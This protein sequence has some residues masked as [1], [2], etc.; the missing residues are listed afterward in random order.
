VIAGDPI[1]LVLDLARALLARYLANQAERRPSG[2]S[3]FAVSPTEVAATLAGEGFPAPRRSPPHDARVD[4]A[5]AALVAH[6][7]GDRGGLGPLGLLVRRLDLDELDLVILATLVAVDLDPELERA[8]SFALDDFTRKRPD[9]GFVVRL[10]GA[11]DR[12]AEA[13]VLA[14]LVDGAALRRRQ[15]V[16]AAGEGPVALRV[17]RAADRVAML[18]RGLDVIDEALHGAAWLAPPIGRDAVVIDDAVYAGIARALERPTAR[19]LLAGRPGTGRGLAVAAVAA[20]RGDPVLR[21]DL[22]R[23]ADPRDARSAERIA[24]AVREAAL[25]G[26]IALFDGPAE[27]DGGE[28]M[29]AALRALAAAAA[30]VATPLALTL[31]S[32]PAWLAAAFPDLVEID[33]P[34]PGLA[35][36]IDLWRRAIPAAVAPPDADLET[37]A[38]RYGF[39]GAAITQAARR[40]VNAAA[41]RDPGGKVG[42]DE[43]SDASRLMFSHQ[44]GG[45]AQRIPTGFTWD[46]LVL[47]A[48]TLAAVREVVTF[49]RQRPFLLE[50][51]GFAKK[52]PYGRGVSAILAGPPGTGKTMVAQLLARELGYELFRIDLSQVVNKYIGETEKNLARIFDEAETAHAVLFFDEADAL[53]G[54]RTEVRSSNDR[55]ANLEV[56]YLLQRMETFDGVTLLATNLEQ[57]IDEAFKRRVRFAVA[58]ELPELDERRRLWRSMFPPEAPLAPDIDWDLIAKTFEMSGG[59]IKKAAL[60]AAVIAA[61]AR[62]RRPLTTQDILGAARAE[63]RE[64]GRIVAG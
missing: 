24:I 7:S 1:G 59:Y 36:R 23:L 38:A 47:P 11:G 21:V 2:P 22:A 42:L 28:A 30:G 43:L 18:L 40:A 41:V 9:V 48:D 61:D 57:G 26:A 13:A 3:P 44:L 29:G 32:R 34:P 55:Y 5:R 63:Y 16:I 25:R 46:D 45:M 62:P 54:K 19:V 12:A 14:R 15:L 56:N 51:W 31:A 50:E 4:A 27:G 60:R 64:M 37:V 52:L 58:F 17:V 10:V 49:A 8:M 35:Q 33:V 53:F 20:E 6:A 39:T